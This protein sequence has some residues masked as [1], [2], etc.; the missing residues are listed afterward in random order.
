M[1]EIRLI[2][3]ISVLCVCTVTA[4]LLV[5][6]PEII[7]VDTKDLVFL[8]SWYTLVISTTAG[9]LVRIHE[10]WTQNL[11]LYSFLVSQNEDR[12]EEIKDN[13]KHINEVERR[14]ELNT[15]FITNNRNNIN[16][17]LDSGGHQ[18]K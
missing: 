2:L 16:K 6:L 4:V 11:K 3:C 5:K 12:R 14:S 9:S 18:R 15:R 17:I 10:Y 1:K 7:I 13:S 8:V